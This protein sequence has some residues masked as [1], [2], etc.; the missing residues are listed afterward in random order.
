MKVSIIPDDRSIIVDGNALNFDFE[1]DTHIHA[2]QWDGE[3]CEIEFK[4]GRANTQTTDRTLIDFLI[5]AYNNE[6]LRREA[7]SQ[8]AADAEA[9]SESNKTYAEKRRSEYPSLPDLTVAL[10]ENVIE[11]RA[12][13]VIALEAKRQAVKAKYPKP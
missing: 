7:E 5:G 9:L 1:I 8:A 12:A 10:W 4:D 3:V 11:E 2:I 13:S 6:A